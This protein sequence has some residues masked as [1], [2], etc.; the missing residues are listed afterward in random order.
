VLAETEETDVTIKTTKGK[1]KIK[2]RK[3]GPV[4]GLI[5]AETLVGI[6]LMDSSSYLSQHP[7]WTPKYAKKGVFG[8]RDLIAK[9]LEG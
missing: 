4:G 8:L 5:V 3:L 6:L 9:A 7:L 2:T 1:R